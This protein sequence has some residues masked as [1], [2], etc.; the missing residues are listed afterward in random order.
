[1]SALKR[2]ESISTRRARGVVG[3]FAPFL[4]ARLRT[5][6]LAYVPFFGYLLY[7]MVRHRSVTLFTAA[8]PGIASGGVVGESKS[9]SLALLRRVDGAVA[10]F[11]VVRKRADMREM[12]RAAARDMTRMGLAF[13]VVLKPDVGER[14]NGV[15]VIRSRKEMARYFR[16]ATCSVIVQRLVEGIECGIFYVHYPDQTRGRIVSIAET[17]FPQVEGDGRHT[18]DEL[19]RRQIDPARRHAARARIGARRLR[20]I[21]AA[22]RR[23]RLVELGFYC[24]EA[25]FRDR[26]G[27]NTPA[28]ERAIERLSRAHPGFHFGRFDVYAKS[29]TALRRGD[30]KVIEL[31]GVIAEATHIYDPSGTLGGALHVLR[32]QWRAAFEIG[33][34]NRARG[35]VPM[36]TGQLLALVWRKFRDYAAALA[37]P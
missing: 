10:D 27:W 29:I 34:A 24:H 33:A 32:E 23:V 28:L 37:I 25:T 11:F 3:L 8:N 14:G 31:N 36:P 15:A 18:L 21:P 13:P 17:C 6:W 20:E 30:I 16:R 12:T 22:G 26:G 7:L 1:M 4:S 2:H 19:L 5:R 9:R 35:A